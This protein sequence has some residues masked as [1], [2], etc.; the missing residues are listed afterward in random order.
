MHSTKN[1]KIAVLGGSGKAGKYIVKQ[2]ILSGYDVKLL[3]RSKKNLDIVSEKIE[4]IEGDGTEYLSLLKLLEDCSGVISSVAPDDKS[5]PVNSKVTDNI[6]KAMNN[7]GIKRF[8]NL[9]GISIDVP[10]DSKSIKTKVLSKTLRMLYAQV[11]KDKQSEFN[12]IQESNVEWTV[13]RSPLISTKEN[14]DSLNINMKDCPGSSIHPD[15]LAK[16]IVSLINDTEFIFKAP[17]VSN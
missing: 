3:T 8:I 16:F 1:T 14:S 12:L 10:G 7:F 4:I 5:N 9:T 6:L 2:L 17:F 15:S 11:I 13:V